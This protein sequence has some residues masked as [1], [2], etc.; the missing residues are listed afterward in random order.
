MAYV[1]MRLPLAEATYLVHESRV[2]AHEANGFV[3][4]EE[5]AEAEAPAEEPKPRTRRK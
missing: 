4:V 5:K 2:K 3:L 1:R